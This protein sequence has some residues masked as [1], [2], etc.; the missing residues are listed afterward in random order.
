MVVLLWLLLRVVES[1]NVTRRA[2]FTSSTVASGT[3]LVLAIAFLTGLIMTFRRITG[4]RPSDVGEKTR[5][6][7]LEGV[8][9]LAP[10]V[11]VGVLGV[12]IGSADTSVLVSSLNYILDGNADW[13]LESQEA[14][15]PHAIYGPLVLA[16]ATV[17]RLVAV[18][19]LASVALALWVMKEVRNRTESDTLAALSGLSLMALPAVYTQASRLP[20]YPLFT[21]AGTVGVV[22]LA[23][24][25]AHGGPWWRPLLGSMGVAVAVATHG[26]GLY[27]FPLS[28]LTLVFIS[29]RAQAVRWFMAMA[30]LGLA[31]TPWLIAHLWVSGLERVST[32]RD[33]WFL[34]EGH[35]LNVNRDFW[36]LPVGTPWET[37]ANLPSLFS[38]ATGSLTVMLVVLA[39]FGLTS[40]S[41]RTR[42]F[43]VCGALTLWVPLVISRSAGFERYYYPV[44][45]AVVLLAAIGA[46]VVV[47]RTPPAVSAGFL[48]LLTCL[49]VSQASQ[50]F[51]TTVDARARGE[52]RLEEVTKV[53]TFIASEG[54]E[55]GVIG[56]RSFL[57]NNV[58]PRIRTFHIDLLSEDDYA[59]FYAWDEVKLRELVARENIRWV[60]LSKPFERWE[61][62]YN[63]AWLA[64]L[65]RRTQ[66]VRALEEGECII[67]DADVFAVFDLERCLQP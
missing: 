54:R 40:V 53:A 2:L 24:Y 57:L 8:L 14:P 5:P 61:E 25:V 52:E 32:P 45:P 11:A 64:P 30:A 21:L 63:N 47:K 20:L 28:L 3:S 58:D 48:L 65:G 51:L 46:S 29:Q 1:A 10:V 36:Q 31:N 7:W 15:V 22:T 35:L 37:L 26:A 16:G 17:D 4:N 13:L 41:H 19:V 34:T 39:G 44:L 55:S 6:W 33:A 12:D 62:G 9:L 43:V 38:R 49:I 67:H 27:Y 42:L 59:S 56:A 60:V 66:H 18:P 23:R 50:S